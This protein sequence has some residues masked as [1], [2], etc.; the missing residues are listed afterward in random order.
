MYGFVNHSD[1]FPT[2][3]LFPLTLARLIDYLEWLPVFGCGGSVAPFGSALLGSGAK[4]RSNGHV[5]R[6]PA[7]RHR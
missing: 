3:P 1:E 7:Q 5:A 4:S 6:G 2:L